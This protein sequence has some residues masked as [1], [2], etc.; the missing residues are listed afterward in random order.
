MSIAKVWALNVVENVVD[1]L[2][3]GVKLVFEPFVVRTITSAFIS[4]NIEASKL[5]S[6]E[7]KFLAREA[8]EHHRDDYIFVAFVC[9]G[10]EL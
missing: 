8:D 6:Q 1:S 9:G 5:Q 10:G 7:S 2:W 3:R 4:L